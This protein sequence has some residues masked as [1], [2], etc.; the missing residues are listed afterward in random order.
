MQKVDPKARALVQ[1]MLTLMGFG[2]IVFGLLIMMNIIFDIEES[3]LFG[4]LL[5]SVGFGDLIISWFVMRK[6]E[7]YN[8][9]Q[10]LDNKYQCDDHHKDQNTENSN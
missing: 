7:K 2:L 10:V 6:N 8:S 4:G 5:I 1:K 3:M 9:R